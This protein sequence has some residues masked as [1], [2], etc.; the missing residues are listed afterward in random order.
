M[1]KKKGFERR[2]S[3]HWRWLKNKAVTLSLSFVWYWYTQSLSSWRVYSST[4]IS[5][6]PAK[7]SIRWCWRSLRISWVRMGMSGSCSLSLLMIFVLC[8]PVRD[9]VLIS[10]LCSFIAALRSEGCVI[11]GARP[12]LLSTLRIHSFQPPKATKWRRTASNGHPTWRLAVPRRWKSSLTR[13]LYVPPRSHCIN[14]LT[15]SSFFFSVRN[16]V[17]AHPLGPVKAFRSAIA[18]AREGHIGAFE[19][20]SIHSSRSSG[21]PIL[22]TNKSSSCCCCCIGSACACAC[23]V[24]DDIWSDPKGVIGEKEGPA[25]EAVE[26]LGSIVAMVVVI[27][28]VNA[29]DPILTLWW[30]CLG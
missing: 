27:G 22:G 20:G 18:A 16:E 28:V 1:T 3:R 17:S 11:G 23:C 21:S 29:E 8:N 14:T 15:T 9:S 26:V 13:D 5:V 10:S 30:W 4:W 2:S 19:G 12:W 7:N 6:R 24:C 25:G